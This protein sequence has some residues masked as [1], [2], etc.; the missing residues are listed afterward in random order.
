MHITRYYSNMS[1]RMWN[2]RDRNRY[3]LQQTVG[4]VQ[5]GTCRKYIHSDYHVILMQSFIRPSEGKGFNWAHSYFF[6]FVC[7]NWFRWAHGLWIRSRDPWRDSGVTWSTNGN[8]S[9]Y[10]GRAEEGYSTTWFRVIHGSTPSN[11]SHIFSSLHGPQQKKARTP[12]TLPKTSPFFQLLPTIVLPSISLIHIEF[13]L[14]AKCMKSSSPPLVWKETWRII[15][16]V[17]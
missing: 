8:Q 5:D 16:H 17:N 2:N 7:M 1:K 3:I 4:A 11:Q 10:E 15:L 6:C 14:S 9:P 12:H 13:L